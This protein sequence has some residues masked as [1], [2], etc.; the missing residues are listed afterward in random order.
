MSASSW[1]AASIA[2]SVTIYLAAWAIGGRAA[3]GL[4]TAIAGAVLALAPLAL[5]R[6]AEWRLWWSLGAAVAAA[7]G[8]IGAFST[9]WSAT[10]ALAALA[11]ALVGPALL[12]LP[13]LAG[14]SAFVAFA[15]VC[16]LESWAGASAWAGTAV[17]I[18]A[19]AAMLT[20]AVVRRGRPQPRPGATWSLALAGA[21]ALASVLVATAVAGLGS[22]PPDWLSGGDWSVAVLLCALAAYC[23][24][25]SLS[26]R[27][28]WGLAAGPVL[29]LAGLLMFLRA[30][31][32]GVPEAYFMV[33]AVWGGVVAWRLSQQ[34]EIPS[35]RD[36]DRHR[37]PDRRVGWPGAAHDGLGTQS[38][39]HQPRHMAYLPCGGH[40]R[41][42]RRTPRSP[43]P[44]LRAG[45]SRAGGLLAD[46]V[47]SL[48]HPQR[49]R[50]RGHRGR[51]PDNAGRGRRAAQSAP[52]AWWQRTPSPGGAEALPTAASPRCRRHRG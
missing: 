45:W 41:I 12:G 23:A 25:W 44:W 10:L 20:P 27:T 34:E 18:V 1:L 17:A 3:A 35:R 8:V 21:L 14:P 48:G 6:K 50:D 16:S 29:L 52:H 15:A 43:L 26:A 4:A 32:V 28:K 7:A 11:A 5:R 51:R 42:G 47:S 2:S 33:V 30:A 36:G 9:P 40:R 37:C 24:G 19:A 31:D 39:E 46:L 13:V 22:A 38:L 49:G